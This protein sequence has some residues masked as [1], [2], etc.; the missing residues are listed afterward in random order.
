LLEYS[1]NEIKFLQS[2]EEARLATSHN[3]IPHVKP[4]SYIF[5]HDTIFVATDYETKSF[6]N[7]KKNPNIAIVID[8][9]KPREHKAVCLQGKVTI[10]EQGKEFETI[11]NLF[12]EKFQWVRDDP[13]QENEAPFL[14]IITTNKISWGLDKNQ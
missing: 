10:I 3:D 7:I 2:L 12:F 11:Y 5:H 14:K 6:Q 13:W 4:V 9:Y 8:I 1:Q